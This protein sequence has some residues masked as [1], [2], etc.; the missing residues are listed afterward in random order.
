MLLMKQLLIVSLTLGIASGIVSAQLTVQET[1]RECGFSPEVLAVAGCTSTHAASLV[2]ELID[3]TGIR[4]NLELLQADLTAARTAKLTI[5]QQIVNADTTDF[6]QLQA[7]LQA[8]S[9]TESLTLQA[10]KQGMESTAQQLSQLLPAEQQSLIPLALRDSARVLPAEYRVLSWNDRKLTKLSRA[11]K[12]ESADSH[13]LVSEAE[14]DYY[15]Q[16]A[17]QYILS[18]RD[19]IATVLS[20][21]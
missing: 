9:D 7:D 16:L 12:L 13:P 17:R 1:L 15:V 2:S 10:Y 11:L 21:Q 8:A 6:D 19:A 18:R 20:D 14:S 5:L 3:D 4:T